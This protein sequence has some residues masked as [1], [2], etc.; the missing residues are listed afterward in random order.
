MTVP[1]TFGTATTSIP[2][3]NLDANFN[4]PITLGNTS[5][6]LGNT[7][8][9]I[10][11]LTLTN[12]TI[13]SGT[14]NIT[15]VTVTTA[16]VTNIT[17][18]GTA[19]IATG[20]ITTLTSTSITDSGLTSGRVTYAG[21]AGLL[22]DS[23]NLLYSGTDLTVYGVRVGRGAGAVASNTVL[24]SNALAANST[25]G[26]VT[27]IGNNALAANTVSYSTAVGA[28]ALA[29]NNSG[30]ANAAFGAYALSTN[31]TGSGN[32]AFGA[33]GFGLSDSALQANLSG[34]YNSAF[35]LGA[36]GKNSSGSNNTAVGYQAG[37]NNTG[38]NNTA[39]GYQALTASVASTGNTAIGFQSGFKQTGGTGNNVFVG[40]QAGYNN[41]TG[42]GLTIIGTAAGFTTAST[43]NNTYIG[44][45]TGY[46]ATG[47]QNTYVGCPSSTQNCGGLMQGG[48]YNT[49]IGNY[50]GNNGGLDIRNSSNYIV[51]SDGQGNPAMYRQ[52]AGSDWNVVG[53]TSTS[54]SG[55][56][57]RNNANTKY[58][59][60]S[61]STTHFYIFDDDASNYVY[62]TQNF[63]AW[64]FASDRRIKTDIVDIEYGLDAVMAMKPRKYKML[65]S[66]ETNI[67]FV[68][69]ELKTVVP[70]AVVG[71]EIKYF[72]TDTPQERAAKTMGVSRDTLIPVLVKAIQEQQAL[73]ESLTT[74]LTA[75][76]NK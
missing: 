17:V 2:L 4:T 67:G 21:T 66:G 35:G 61:T 19:N 9:T 24:G 37:Y 72:D 47:T 31:T 10:G 68:A 50:S 42:T 30:A 70:E 57:F 33:L 34:S 44:Q 46:E 6:Y 25:G 69:Q 41:L 65:A 13:S 58:W 45:G 20:N 16:N 43:N 48:N 63:T 74:R 71:E 52:W 27:A 1:Y 55:F 32:S 23:A 38:S 53:D 8:T 49:I 60:I 54:C 15:N 62:L 12:A 56:A 11:N 36:L 51:L 26:E 14:V 73:I 18:T 39:V 64:T 29:A 75:L 28:N 59:A 5:I 40:N 76:E 7:T 22:Q 3:S